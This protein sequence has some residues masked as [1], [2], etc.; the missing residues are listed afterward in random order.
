MWYV[1]SSKASPQRL[2][3]RRGLLRDAGGPSGVCPASSHQLEPIILEK[4]KVLGAVS[5][6]TQDSHDHSLPSVC[7]INRCGVLYCEGGQKPPERSS[8]TF[9]SNY[10]ICHALHTDSNTETYELVLQGTKCE[11]GK[12][13]CV[14]SP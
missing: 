1:F 3:H 5:C 13:S 2:P 6:T 14:R 12:V 7:R 4:G 11:E 10:E 8:C 9:S